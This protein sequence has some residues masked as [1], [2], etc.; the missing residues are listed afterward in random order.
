MRKL[1]FIL[2]LSIALGFGYGIIQS[3]ADDHQ[4]IIDRFYSNEV[5]LSERMAYELHVIVDSMLCDCTNELGY[6]LPTGEGIKLA[7]NRRITF[8]DASKEEKIS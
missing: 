4:D 6:A 5:S 7:V 3:Q 2:I 8:L 1:G